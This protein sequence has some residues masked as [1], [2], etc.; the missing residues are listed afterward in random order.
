M[1]SHYGKVCGMKCGSQAF[2]S[3]SDCGSESTPA[4]R[5]S[6]LHTNIIKPTG[7]DVTKT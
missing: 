3:R 7:E 4:S 5:N 6:D 2:L 1:V